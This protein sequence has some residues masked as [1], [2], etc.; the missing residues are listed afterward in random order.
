MSDDLIERVARKMDPLAWVEYGD[1]NHRAITLIHAEKAIPAVIEAL[2]ARADDEFGLD[3]DTEQMAD[4]LRSQ[5]D[6]EPEPD[7]GVRGLIEGMKYKFNNN[8]TQ[9]SKGEDEDEQ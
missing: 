5:L 2:I 4:W 6:A 1:R 3:P 7:P 9:K 8:P